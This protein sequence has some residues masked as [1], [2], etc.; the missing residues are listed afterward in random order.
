MPVLCGACHEGIDRLVQVL[1]NRGA[2]PNARES[3]S[4]TCMHSFTKLSLGLV[5]YRPFTL[6]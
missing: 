6:K 1:L 3:V 5:P 4:S 2:D